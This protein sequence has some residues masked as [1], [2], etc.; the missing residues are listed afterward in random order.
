MRKR[1]RWLMPRFLCSYGLFTIFFC[2]FVFPGITRAYRFDTGNSDFT[3]RWDN[4]LK[5]SAAARVEKQSD[6]LVGDI[7]QDDGDRNFD[8]GLI[9]NR[10]DVLSEMDII[11]KAYGVRISAAAWYDLVYNESNANDSPGTANAFSVS[12]DEFTEDTRDLH[13]RDA[14]ILDAFVFGKHY[15]GDNALSF[16]A[17]RY[18]LQWGESI[19]FGNNGIAGAMAPV[20]IVKLLSVPNSQFKEIVRSV[21]QVS[22][23]MQIGSKLSIGAYYQFKWEKTR[24]PASGSYFSNSDPIGEGGERL[25]AGPP[26][27]PGGGNAAF[28]RGDDLE[29]DDEGQG[30]IQVRYRIGEYDFGAYAIRY[31]DKVHQLYATPSVVDTPGGPVVLDPQNFDPAS[32][33]IGRYYHIYPENIEVYGLSAT[34]TFGVV[35]LA[36]EVS[37]RVNTPLVS[38]LQIALPGTKADNDENPLYA[39]GDSF[40]AQLSW[41]ATLEPNFIAN[42]SDFVGEI[43]YNQRTRITKNPEAL[44]P[45]TTKEAIGIRMVYEPKYRQI[46]PGIDLGIPIGLAYFPIGSSS[47]IANF[48]PDKGG[49]VNIGLNITYLD[50]WRIGLAYTHYYGSAGTFLDANNTFSFD[51]PNADRDFVSLSVS[52]TF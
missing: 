51:Q 2:V 46:L 25:F 5:Y 47:V 42:E 49:D 12:H 19:F 31:H 38:D 21:P 41:I 34:T 32:G 36:A 13:G 44:A 16:R 1:I 26:L 39:V 20:D 10:L 43:A 52:C 28:F 23:Q 14:E 18:A 22:A 33:M 8:Q 45:N 30:G 27:M 50:F 15:F 29:A 4:T 24:L 3:I 7:N 40:H 6:E 17:G 11:Y 48:G 35:N 37:Y 9:S